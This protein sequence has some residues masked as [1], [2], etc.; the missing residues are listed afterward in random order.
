[1]KITLKSSLA[2]T[3]IVIAHIDIALNSSNQLQKYLKIMSFKT[4]KKTTNLINDQLKCFF[5]FL[6]NFKTK[7]N[8]N[9]PTPNT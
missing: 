7:Y 6:F 3:F 4:F 9:F 8:Y 1:M 2:F 5:L